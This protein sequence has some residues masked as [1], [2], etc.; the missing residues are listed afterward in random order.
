[1][2]FAFQMPDGPAWFFFGVAAAL[3][4]GPAVATRLKLPA[5]VG[6]LVGGLVIGPYVLGI[7]PETDSTLSALGQLGLLYLM[8]T[9]GA[10]LD[11]LLFRRYKRA[12]LT[13]ALITFAAPMTLGFLGGVLLRYEVAACILLGSL[14]ASH[15]L[16]T[17]PMVR[18][19]GLS[20]NRAV[21]TTVAATG[22]TDTLSLLV[23]AAVSGSVTG[24][25]SLPVLVVSL[26]AGLV[27]LA[28]YTLVVLPA[29]T[30]WVYTH[31]LHS[32]TERFAFVLAALLSAAVVAEIGSIEGLVG[33]FLAGVG[34][35]RMLPAGSALME[36]VEFFGSALLVPVFLLSVGVL[37][38]PSVVVQPSTLGVAV[39]FCASVIGGKW[40]AAHLS[41]RILGFTHGEANVMFGLS[42]SQAAATLAATFVGFDI[43][44]FGEQVVNAVLVVILVTLLLAALTTARAL[45]GIE[46]TAS[47]EGTPLGSKLV[48]VAGR[49]DRIA[50]LAHVAQALVG[51]EGG[52]VAPIRVAVSSDD[53]EADRSLLAAAEGVLAKAGL[54]TEPRLR[55]DDNPISA[56]AYTAIEDGASVVLMDWQAAARHQPALRGERDDGLLGAIPVPVVLAAMSD[57]PFARVVLA[58]DRVDL[59]PD[60]QGD[61]ALAVEVATRLAAGDCSRLLVGAGVHEETAPLFGGDP[62]TVATLDRS[63]WVGEE[64]RPGDMVVM[65]AHPLWA[66]FGSTA[67][68]AS[69]HAGVSV[70]VVADPQRWAGQASSLERTIGALVG[71][72]LNPKVRWG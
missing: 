25:Q 52:M 35:N 28:V 41:S 70:L 63:T 68:R 17:Y 4:I 57:T 34:L 61:L 48:L 71:G 53:I 11:L 54:D 42:L 56:I 33:A 46:P 15:T 45:P 64:A 7:V 20:G 16:V 5:I 31:V 30:R 13:F 66:A 22:V 32:R 58:L 12:A 23:L 40:I 39:V 1:V 2:I 29:L 49:E 67:V 72:N 3:V 43:G 44:L 60:S 26:V 51:P 69:A 37:I 50:G 47:G 9:A 27:M 36:R 8:F 14:W 55:I 6:L 65:P 10:E 38:K 62:G 59:R 21:A 24:G 19:A 18:E